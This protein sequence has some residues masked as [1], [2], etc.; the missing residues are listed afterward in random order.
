MKVVF[1][2]TPEFAVPSLEAVLAAGHE[3]PLVLTQPDRPAGRRLELQAPPVK[4]LAQGRGIRVLQPEKIR[5]NE[6]LRGS[7]E[8]L[9]PDV[10]VVVAYGR[11]IPPWMLRLPRFGNLNVHASLLPKY[12]GAAPIQ[13]A[14]ANGE[15]ETGVSIMQLDQG[16]DTGDVFVRVPVPIAPDALAVE[17]FP[18][19]ARVGAS[20]LLDV[21]A[22][23]EEGTLGAVPQVAE[24]ATLAPILTR[25]DGRMELETRAARQVYDCWRGF[26]PWPG[27]HGVFRQKRFIVHKMGLLSESAGFESAGLS[28]H[29]EKLVAGGADGRGV[30]L[31]EVQVEGKARMSGAQFARD[32][33]LQAGERLG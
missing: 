26:Y 11:V 6:E 8:A 4:T 12:R 33:Q 20:A 31:E 16:L 24:E 28:V 7:L 5:S 21:L 29:D 1:C 32:F 27:A 30:V 15:R 25:E 22:G 18:E 9:R 13:W 23:L 19:L 10:I 3:V 17:L 2:G 14:V